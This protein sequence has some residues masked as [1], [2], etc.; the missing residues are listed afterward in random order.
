MVP[1]RETLN[2]SLDA[3]GA[4]EE[5]K[6]NGTVAVVAAICREIQRQQEKGSYRS[7]FLLYQHAVRQLVLSSKLLKFY[8]PTIEATIYPGIH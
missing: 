8:F 5:R 6:R 1:S 4:M 3:V 2:R 7:G